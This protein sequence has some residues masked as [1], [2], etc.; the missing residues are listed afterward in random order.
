MSGKISLCFKLGRVTEIVFIGLVVF[1]V[2]VVVHVVV[3]VV[4]DAA[5]PVGISVVK[6]FYRNLR[7][8]DCLP[9]INLSLYLLAQL[10]YSIMHQLLLL[11]IA[12]LIRYS[13]P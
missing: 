8:M 4:I 10:A 13:E 2:A 6:P 3:V 12:F 5:V 7:T 11:N 9:H 1:V